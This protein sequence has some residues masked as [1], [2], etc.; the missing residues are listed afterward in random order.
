MRNAPGLAWR[1]HAV[2]TLFLVSCIGLAARAAYLAT[3]ERDFLRDKGEALSVRDVPIPVHR[4]MIF[5][6]HGEPLA[7]SAPMST[8]G[9]DPQMA[10]LTDARFS[11]ASPMRWVSRR[12]H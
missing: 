7:V 9:V 2:W 5:D 4:G 12:R 3:T 10:A 6:R 8:I 11:P 1:H